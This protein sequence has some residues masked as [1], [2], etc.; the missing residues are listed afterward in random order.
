MILKTLYI[1]LKLKMGHGIDTQR[2]SCT[3]QT[4][5]EISKKWKNQTQTKLK[6]LEIK[7]ILHQCDSFKI[8]NQIT[9]L[10]FNLLTN[11]YQHV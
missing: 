9:N 2:L 3:N 6:L 4:T 1:Y 11:T 8:R 5:K 7:G 10:Q